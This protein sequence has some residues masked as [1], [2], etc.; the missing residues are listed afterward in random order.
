ME[1]AL[2]RTVGGGGGLY[3][4]GQYPSANTGRIYHNLSTSHSLSTSGPIRSCNAPPMYCVPCRCLNRRRS[5]FYRR[6]GTTTG[7][8]SPRRL[9]LES[10]ILNT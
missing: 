4:P 1:P 9:S 2:S 8:Y 10:S 3:Y 6:I 7:E 5:R